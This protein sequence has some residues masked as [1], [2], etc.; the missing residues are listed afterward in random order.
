[1]FNLFL[2]G[3]FFISKS[4]LRW[5]MPSLETC[6]G[7][8]LIRAWLMESSNMFL[9]G[10]NAHMHFSMQKLM[11]RGGIRTAVRKHLRKWRAPTDDAAS[12]W[13][14]VMSLTN[15]LHPSENAY[16]AW[17]LLGCVFP[18]SKNAS[19]HF[20][21]QMLLVGWEMPSTFF[22]VPKMHPDISHP[23]CFL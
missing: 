10:G 20:S 14:M 12:R 11:G 2:L 21:S 23:K 5:K 6:L 9:R 13:P 18:G 4:Q 1:M 19:G 7:D 17:E 16:A 15:F 8:W 3:S 22:Q